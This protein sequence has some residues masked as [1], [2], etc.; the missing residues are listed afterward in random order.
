MHPAVA[1]YRVATARLWLLLVGAGSL[2]GLT[3]PL[4]RIAAQGGTHAVTLALWQAVVSALGLVAVHLALRWRLPLSGQHVRFYAVCGLMGTA[5]PTSLYYLAAVH[6]P[7]GVLAITIATVPMMTLLLAWLC[8]IERPS[9]ARV[10]GLV[11]GILGVAFLVL[12]EASLP[13]PAAVPWVLLVVLC[14]ACYAIENSYIALDLPP[15]THPLS[16]LLGM[17]IAAALMTAPVAFVFG[18]L[19]LP[20]LPFGWPEISLFGMAVLSTVA[21]TVFVYLVGAG[22]PV[23]ASQIAYVVTLT[24]VAWGMVLLGEAH[25]GWVWAALAVMIVGLAL[26]KPGGDAAGSQSEVKP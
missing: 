25:S 18:V 11:A 8:R 9:M 6:V 7:S 2:W 22:G 16:I 14:A 1:S 23:F 15:D 5:L 13:D 24:G 17:M 12:P 19:A 4:A 26:V 3:F 20:S 21:Y 10:A